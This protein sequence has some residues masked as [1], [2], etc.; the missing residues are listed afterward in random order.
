MLNEQSRLEKEKLEAIQHEEDDKVAKEQAALAEKASSS[1]S[2]LEDGE[3]KFDEYI[4]AEQ[5]FK[6]TDAKLKS[7]MVQSEHTAAVSQHDGMTPTSVVKSEH[8]S[9]ANSEFTV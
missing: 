8:D 3:P 4:K 7:A 9:F 6:G 1:S 2:L 5:L